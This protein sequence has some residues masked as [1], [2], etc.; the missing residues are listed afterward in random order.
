MDIGQ[1]DHDVRL[2]NKWKDLKEIKIYSVS[3]GSL[4]WD[5]DHIYFFHIVSR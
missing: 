3:E 5:F 2:N 1:H 4:I